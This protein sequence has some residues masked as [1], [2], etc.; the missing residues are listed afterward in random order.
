[1]EDHLL[2]E[3][4]KWHPG[5]YYLELPVRTH[6]H[7]TGAGGPATDGTDILT[8]FTDPAGRLHPWKA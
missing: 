8:A 5:I 2:W 4:L 6:C 1:M 7:R 3:H